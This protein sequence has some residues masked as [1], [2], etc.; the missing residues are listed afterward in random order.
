[1]TKIHLAKK[2]EGDYGLKCKKS[3]KGLQKKKREE[4]NRK[5]AAAKNRQKNLTK[6]EGTTRRHSRKKHQ[7]AKRS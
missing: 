7:E 4:G 5:G 6:G 1:V 2:K 3:A